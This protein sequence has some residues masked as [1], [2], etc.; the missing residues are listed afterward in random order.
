MRRIRQRDQR[1]FEGGALHFGG[2][3]QV[4]ENEPAA[5]LRRQ[6]RAIRGAHEPVQAQRTL[7]GRAA[8]VAKRPDLLVEQPPRGDGAAGC[9]ACV[10]GEGRLRR[11]ADRERGAEQL[12]R[13]SGRRAAD[14]GPDFAPRRPEARAEGGPGRGI[15]GQ[16]TVFEV[17][18]RVPPRA[19]RPEPRRARAQRLPLELEIRL[20][21]RLGVRGGDLAP[22]PAPGQLRQPRSAAAEGV[23]VR[24]LPRRAR[25]VGRG[26]VRLRP[27]RHQPAQEHEGDRPRDLGLHRVPGRHAEDPH[28]G[29]V[30]VLRVR[31]A[32]LREEPGREGG[33]GGGGG[34]GVQGEGGERLEERGVHRPLRI[35]VRGRRVRQLRLQI[36]ARARR[37]RP[38]PRVQP[39][40]GER[41]QHRGSLS[42]QEASA[43][44]GA[45]A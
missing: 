30:V 37:Q 45:L 10:L 33:A 24:V 23:V 25:R 13:R 41:L 35:H 11:R 19:V 29:V 42:P 5:E 39:G 9:A 16:G 38:E 6:P 43:G 17:R 15:V 1:G 2:Q 34:E 27:A 21:P 22:Q 32:G 28:E 4:E 3:P 12:H 40:G 14:R 8:E 44:Q 7:A 31:P 20:V 26:V 18:R 36:E